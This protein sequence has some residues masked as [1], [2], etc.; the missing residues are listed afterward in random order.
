[1]YKTSKFFRGKYFG[2]LKNGQKK[3]PKMRI[4]KYF[5]EKKTVFFC[6]HKKNYGVVAKKYFS[7]L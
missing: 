4:P 5:P 7:N 1:M 2:I 6:D 3:C